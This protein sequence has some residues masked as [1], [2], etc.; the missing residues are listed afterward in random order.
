MDHVWERSLEYLKK[1]HLAESK[2]LLSFQPILWIFEASQKK[3][4]RPWSIAMVE[5]VWIA[6]SAVI[7]DS[8]VGVVVSHLNT[9]NVMEIKRGIIRRRGVMQGVQH[10]LVLNGGCVCE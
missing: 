8:G 10:V 3:S 9:F 6:F 2:R 7:I 1:D 4:P 5:K